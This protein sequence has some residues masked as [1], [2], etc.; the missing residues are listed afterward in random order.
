MKEKQNGIE[1]MG[2]V[3]GSFAKV[4]RLQTLIRWLGLPFQKIL[5]RVGGTHE[6]LTVQSVRI[7]E[8]DGWKNISRHCSEHLETIIE[9][10]YWADTLWKN[11]THHYN[12]NTKKGLWL[13]P[14]AQDQINNWFNQAVGFWLKGKTEKA[15]HFL[16]ACLHIVQDCCQPYH[17][18]LVIFR[19]HQKYEKWADAHKETFAV[20]CGG[21][22]RFSGEAGNWAAD[23]AKFSKGFFEAVADSSPG[24]VKKRKEATALLLARA[25]RTTAGFIVFFFYKMKLACENSE[26]RENQVFLSSMLTRDE[27]Y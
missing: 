9:G 10:N 5:D 16:G 26:I 23:N 17:S 1:L 11:T 15:L 21:T 12:P 24:A 2:K 14:G 13:W 19:G 25:Q 18:N 8:N 7:L 27:G 3:T 20:D 4:I 22:Y 6:F